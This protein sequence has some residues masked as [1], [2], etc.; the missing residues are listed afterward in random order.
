M[1]HSPLPW[2]VDPRAPTAIFDANGQKVA[3]TTEGHGFPPTEI[4]QARADAALI[5]GMS[6][7]IEQM[8]AQVE[9]AARC[10]KFVI[11][12]MNEGPWQGTDLPGDV[13]QDKA[14]EIGLISETK[15]D[16]EKHK[17]PDWVS[18]EAGESWFTIDQAIFSLASTEE[19]PK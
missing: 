8:R 9:W 16:P 6:Q 17:A 2:K 1:T 18:P 3:A 14:Q 7:E 12:A 15:F 4:D 5:A 10:A 19:Q 11:W 13:I